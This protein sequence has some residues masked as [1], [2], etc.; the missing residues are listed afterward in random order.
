MAKSE[1]RD[2]DTRCHH[3]YWWEYENVNKGNRGRCRLD[4]AF[5][6]YCESERN[7]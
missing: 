5:R 3:C 2:G 7:K 6:K 1:Y 4:Y